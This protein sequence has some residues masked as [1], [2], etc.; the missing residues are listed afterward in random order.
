MLHF[1]ATPFGGGVAEIL[2]SLVPL[3]NDIGIATEWRVMSAGDELFKVTK[4]MHNSLQGKHVP[5]TKK[6]WDTWLSY[7]L[8]TLWS[9]MATTIWWWST[10]RILPR[11]W[12]Q[13][14][15]S[16]SDITF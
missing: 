10:T 5:W 8:Q 9:W 11:G 15:G 2:K 7:N 4:T 6:M 1:N 14:E 13:R 3:L 16:T 12:D